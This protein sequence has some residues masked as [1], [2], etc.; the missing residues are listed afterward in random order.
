MHVLVHLSHEWREEKHD[1]I[2][3]S[4]LKR[5]RSLKKPSHSKGGTS[6][7]PLFE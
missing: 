4:K 2:R 5:R 1:F 6:K 3:I 7:V